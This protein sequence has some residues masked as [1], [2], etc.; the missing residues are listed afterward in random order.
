MKKQTVLAFLILAFIGGLT[1]CKKNETLTAGSGISTQDG[2][3]L[4][5]GDGMWDLLGYG[6]DVTDDMQGQNSTSDAPIIDILR[7]KTD[8]PNSRTEITSTSYGYHKSY[9]GAT[10]I[11]YMRDYS[12][13]KSFEV[14]ANGTIEGEKVEG[15]SKTPMQYNFSG[16]FN[17]NSTDQ[18]ILTVLTKYSYASYEVTRVIKRLRFNQD[19]TV[20]LLNQ[21]LTPEFINYV[22]TMSAENIVARYGT[23]VMLDISIGGILRFNYSGAVVK[24]TEF[25]KKVSGIKTG[26]SFGLLKLINVNLSQDKTTTEIAQTSNEIQERDYEGRYF[27]GTNSGIS[28]SIDKDGNTAQNVNISSFESGIT[29][30][31]AAL[32]DVGRAIFIYH[33]IAD[34]VKKEQVRI[35]VEK[36]ITDSQRKELGEVP[37]YVYNSNRYGDHYYTTDNVPS[38]GDGSYYNEGLAF[39]AFPSPTLGAVPI[40]V[41]NGNGD[42][43]YTPDNQPT[44]GGGYFRNEGIAFYAYPT[45]VTGSIPI[46]VYNSQRHAD[47]YYTPENRLWI[48]D[49]SY[50]NEGIAF[51][52]IQ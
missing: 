8:F 11:D 13:Q 17:Q 43:Y 25:S 37:I 10:A 31:N 47:H 41:Y 33:F 34:P 30:T 51:Y 3:K 27:G 2:S 28:I 4:S 29:P 39:Y 22:N 1:G 44:I 46:Y 52:A 5:G 45:Q 40:Y 26:F 19:A 42:H 15:S 35:A 23:H 12:K 50:R 7:F 20:E 36:H 38:I 18:N 6:L 48:G 14:K 32:V 16:S 9:S 49:G 24:E 21:Y